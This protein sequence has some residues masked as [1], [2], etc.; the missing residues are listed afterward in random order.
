MNFDVVIGNPPYQIDAEGNSRTMP[1]YQ[2]FIDA[3]ISL[4]PH[5]IVMI[6]PSRWFA[7]GLGLDAFRRNMLSDRR[8][9][10]LVDF[11]NASEV[12]PGVSIEGG[13]S[14]FLWNASHDGPAATQTVRAGVLSQ[15]LTRSLDEF[16]VFVRE[17]EALPI[18]RKVLRAKSAPFAD[19][20]SAQKP[21]GLLS[22]FPSFTQK[23][24]KSDDFRFYGVAKGKRTEGWVK[25]TH[26]T[27]NEELAATPKVLLPEA[28]GG[29]P[30]GVADLVL[31]RPWVVP[32]NSVCTQTFMF[33]SVKNESEARSVE[34]YI[35]TKF[36]RFLVSLRKISQH[37]KADTYIWVPQQTWDRSWTDAELYKKYKLTK[38]EIAL[39]ELMIRPMLFDS[40]ATINE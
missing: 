22:N 27:M 29:A 24:V 3:A 13:V 34:S 8:I 38:D 39:I 14:Y 4:D 36:F 30:D 1:I 11:P 15:V 16:D 31:G 35:A 32:E 2:K 40:D 28:R 21:F 33:V 20:V 9:K 37:T 17:G 6:T 26:I 5:Y 23:K 25:R 18:L 19:L 12:F 10:V 7:G